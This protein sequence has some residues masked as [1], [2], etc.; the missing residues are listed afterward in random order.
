MGLALAACGQKESAE[1]SDMEFSTERHVAAYTLEGSGTA[2]D[3]EDARDFSVACRMVMVVPEK[4]GYNDLTSLHEA[5]SAAYGRTDSISIDDFFRREVEELGYAATPIE[6]TD[7]AARELAMRS[8]VPDIYDGYACINGN[9]TNLTP[10]YMSY[11]V[12]T[13]YYAPRTAHG[14]YAMRYV[15]YDIAGGKVITLNELILP[16]ARCALLDKVRE[17]ARLMSG[18]IGPN[19]IQSLPENDNFTITANGDLVLVYQPYEAA[20]FS[21]GIIEIP[22]EPYTIESMLSDYGRSILMIE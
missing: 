3:G 14:S 1:R 22:I 19:W 6:L 21:Q 16:I 20:S 9:V 2:M 15:N 11:A 18:Y 4:L 8:G 13:S 12:Y 5:I 10:S 17:T 7:S